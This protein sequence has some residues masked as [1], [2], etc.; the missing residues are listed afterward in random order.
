MEFLPVATLVLAVIYIGR[1]EYDLLKNG[2]YSG[3][4]M[5]NLSFMICAVPVLGATIY[6]LMAMQSRKAG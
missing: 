6:Y 1:A 4:R 5:A 3:R 2:R